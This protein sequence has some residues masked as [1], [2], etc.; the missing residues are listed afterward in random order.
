LY[1]AL[2]SLRSG[3]STAG[4]EGIR[5]AY[6]LAEQNYDGSAVNR[7]ILATDGDFNNN[8]VDAGDIDAGHTVIAIHEI[9]PKNAATKLIDDLRYGKSTTTSD[10]V[11]SDECAFLKIRYKLPSSSTSTLITTPITTAL[12][13]LN[14]TSAPRETRFATAVA[15]FGQLIR[16]GRHTEDY[17]YDDVIALAQ[18]AK[19]DDEYGYRAEFTNLVRLAKSA[20]TLPSLQR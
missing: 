1:A 6:Q 18:S 15:A 7:V 16:G 11:R 12:E 14:G 2:D 20:A 19:G 8:K 5:Q 9:T 13:S 10:L 3:G 4:D 17:S